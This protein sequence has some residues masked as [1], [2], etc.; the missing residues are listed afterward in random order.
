LINIYRTPVS[1]ELRRKDSDFAVCGGNPAFKQ[2]A[3][4]AL[5]K[6]A[7]ANEP[8]GNSA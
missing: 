8:E 1:G 6:R 7:P 3:A 5:Q 2:D 4:V